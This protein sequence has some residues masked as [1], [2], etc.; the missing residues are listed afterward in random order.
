MNILRSPISSHHFR[1]P[2]ILISV[3]SVVFVFILI[4]KQPCSRPT[5]AA[6]IVHSKS[7]YN[8]LYCNLPKY[9]INRLQQI[10]N[11]LARSAVKAPKFSHII[12]I[13][14]SLHW[15][16]LTSLFN[17]VPYN[18]NALGPAF[19]QSP[20]FI[21]EELSIKVLQPRQPLEYG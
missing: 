3:N 9:K 6:S 11:C 15:L 5:I 16:I 21:I 2:V 14:K 1:S 17:I 13:L 7:D 10:Q 19:F 8:C 18:R 12:P 20:D 4:L